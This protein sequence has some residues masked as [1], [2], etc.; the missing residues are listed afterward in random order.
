MP[1]LTAALQELIASGSLCEDAR[2]LLSGHSLGG[3]L[4]VCSAAVM[5]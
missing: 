1:L 5:R 4:A 2:F 3:A